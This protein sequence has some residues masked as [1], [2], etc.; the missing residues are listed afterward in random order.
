MMIVFLSAGLIAMIMAI[1]AVGLLSRNRCLRGS[2]G[3]SEIFDADGESL[4]CGACPNREE[5]VNKAADQTTLPPVT[6]TTAP[7]T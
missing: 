3:G 7:V 5:Q 6:N 4:S 1:M 2:C